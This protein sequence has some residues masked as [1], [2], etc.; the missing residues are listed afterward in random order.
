MSY[1]LNDIFELGAQQS[2]TRLAA[3]DWLGLIIC[4]AQIIPGR[5]GRRSAITT[6]FCVRQ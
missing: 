4:T 2:V 6:R 1:R 3:E 5:A